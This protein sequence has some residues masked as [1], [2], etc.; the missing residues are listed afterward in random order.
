MRL[1][2][3]IVVVENNGLKAQT[4]KKALEAVNFYKEDI[5]TEWHKVFDK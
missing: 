3:E 2:C 1:P 4:I 5:V